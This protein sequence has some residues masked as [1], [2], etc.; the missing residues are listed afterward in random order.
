MM[1]RPMISQDQWKHQPMN[2]R[3]LPAPWRASLVAHL[4]KNPPTMWETWVRS[5]GWE[6]PLEEGMATHSSILAW[7]LPRRSP[8]GCSPCGHKEL[9]T[10]NWLSM[11]PKWLSMGQCS[12]L[13]RHEWWHFS[14]LN[15]VKI[16]ITPYLTQ[17][18]PQ[19]QQNIHSGVTGATILAGFM[20]PS[21][22]DNPKG[23][24]EKL[25]L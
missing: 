25:A 19:S 12:Q 9:D 21:S 20:P 17:N 2:W 15:C 16:Q 10:A 22:S 13:F 4:V 1:W 14:S 24:L 11:A 18:L 23:K 7:R 3:V 6:D 5:L 8:V